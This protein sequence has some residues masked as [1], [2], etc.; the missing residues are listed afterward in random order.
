MTENRSITEEQISRDLSPI[1]ELLF[2]SLR[3]KCP[4]LS[5]SELSP[6]LIPT[7]TFL[8]YSTHVP[9]QPDQVA[10]VHHSCA[11]CDKGIQLLVELL[12]LPDT[13]ALVHPGNVH[14]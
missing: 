14:P 6:Q 4:E 1:H 12:I 10:Q 2:N 3:L 8:L 9:V 5:E 11:I 7:N 13:G